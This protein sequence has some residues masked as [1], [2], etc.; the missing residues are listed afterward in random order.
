[1]TNA[2]SST[3]QPSAATLYLGSHHATGSLVVER[4][5]PTNPRGRT[6][7]QWLVH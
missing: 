7:V 2:S 6:R 3:E 4:Y 1:M 5:V